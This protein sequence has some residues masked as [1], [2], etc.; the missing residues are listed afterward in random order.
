M[1][2]DIEI[3]I[4]EYPFES[5]FPMASNRAIHLIKEWI[6]I[7]MQPLMSMHFKIGKELGE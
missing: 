2:A 3:R 4:K 7:T 5:K 1:R 6:L